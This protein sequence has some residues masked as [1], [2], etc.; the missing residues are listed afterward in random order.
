MQIIDIGK[1]S[2]CAF[3][4]EGSCGFL[5]KPPDITKSK[6]KGGGLGVRVGG[7]GLGVGMGDGG[8]GVGTWSIGLV[9]RNTTHSLL[10][11]DPFSL[12]LHAYFRPNPQPPTPNPYLHP[13]SQ[14]LTPNPYSPPYTTNPIE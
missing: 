3:T 2:L 11:L 9:S 4:H 6:T 5:A 10:Q 13:S 12:T 8:W 7:W 14:L 1:R